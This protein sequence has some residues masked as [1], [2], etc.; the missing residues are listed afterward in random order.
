MTE[1]ERQEIVRQ[2]PNGP[3]RISG[4]CS[5]GLADAIEAVLRATVPAESDL[6]IALRLLDEEAS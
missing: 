5:P 6:D 2:L 3:L 1:P 4:P